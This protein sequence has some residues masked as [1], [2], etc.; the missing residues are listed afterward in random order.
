[1]LDDDLEL[2]DDSNLLQEE[3]FKKPNP[4]SLLGKSIAIL[5]TH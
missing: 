3:D 4:E 1:M 2:I 5:L